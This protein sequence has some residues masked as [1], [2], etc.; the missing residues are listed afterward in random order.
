MLFQK[1]QSKGTYKSALIIET[2]AEFFKFGEPATKL[3]EFE[4]KMPVGA[5]ALAVTA[6]IFIS[7][8]S[9][10][11]LI[12]YQVER[13]LIL[14]R[15]DHFGY[16]DDMLYIKKEKVL[17]KRALKGLA[18]NSSMDNKGPVFKEVRPVKLD[19]SSTNFK[20]KVTGWR[21]SIENKADTLFPTICDTARGIA[22]IAAA[23]ADPT[24][25]EHQ[26]PQIMDRA[27]LASEDE[28]SAAE[29][30]DDTEAQAKS[31]NG[32]A[33]FNGTDDGNGNGVDED[34]GGDDEDNGGNDGNGS[35][36]NGD[37]RGDNGNGSGVDED[38]GGDDNNEAGLSYYSGPN[39]CG[40]GG[41]DGNDYKGENEEENDIADSDLTD[42]SSSQEDIRQDYDA[43]SG[44]STH[45][46][47]VDFL[48]A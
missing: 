20:A 17:D 25:L 48:D 35:G 4:V 37:N 45:L 23:S 27:N 47:A 31:D 29:H 34:N 14:Y 3:P 21:L 10:Q 18:D 42:V 19:F 1:K 2:F 12:V 11:V 8:I 39:G 44:F 24:P 28:D 40:D 43:A 26:D 15:D 5:L 33:D 7:L 16:K 36:V 38:E 41:H 9:I 6:V 13:A 22:G 46:L 30:E 32:R